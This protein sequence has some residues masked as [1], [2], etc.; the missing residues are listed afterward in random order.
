MDTFKKLT[1]QLNIQKRTYMSNYK[2]QS[3]VYISQESKSKK[4]FIYYFDI[5]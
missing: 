5:M 4:K 2:K 1:Y 3:V